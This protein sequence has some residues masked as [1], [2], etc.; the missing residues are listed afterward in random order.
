MKLYFGADYYPEH[1]LEERWPEDA[2]L[3][4]EAGFNV[5]RLAEFAWSKMEPS[6]GVFDFDWLDRA[7]EIFHKKG[8]SVILGTPTASPPP[9]L[10]YETPEILRVREDGSRLVFGTRRINCPSHPLYRERSRNITTAMAEHYA[11]NPAV[12]GWQTDNEFG[13]RCYSGLLHRFSELA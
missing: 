13:D 12:I 6:E 4:K 7:V 2:R 9:W 11:S 3:M 1:W 8:I 5:V 10:A